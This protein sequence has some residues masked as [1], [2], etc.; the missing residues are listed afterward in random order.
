ME[1]KI[2]KIYEIIM[3]VKWVESAKKGTQMTYFKKGLE[4][5]L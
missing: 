4:K 3:E 1:V 5:V 2:I